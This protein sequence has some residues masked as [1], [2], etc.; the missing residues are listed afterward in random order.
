MALYKGYNSDTNAS[1][2]YRNMSAVLRRFR[3]WLFHPASGAEY[4]VL[5]VGLDLSGKTELLKRMA[6]GEIMVTIPTIGFAVEAAEVPVKTARAE[7]VDIMCWD[8]VG[9]SKLRYFPAF[10]EPFLSGTD[11]LVWVF[12]GTDLERMSESSDELTRTVPHSVSSARRPCQQGPARRKGFP[13]S[14]V[15]ATLI[16]LQNC[17]ADRAVLGSGSF[18]TGRRVSQRKPSPP[19]PPSYYKTCPIDTNQR[20]LLEN[21]LEIWLERAEADAHT[22]SETFLKQFADIKLPSWD[23]YTHIR[24]AYPILSIHG[25]QKGKNI[26]FDG[27]ENYVSKSPQAKTRAF[28]LTMTYFWIQMVHWAIERVRIQTTKDHKK[29]N[30]SPISS[31]ETLVAGAP[32]PSPA[33][34]TL[35]PTATFAMFLAANPFLA[36]GRLW[37][38]YYSTEVLMSAGAMVLP[39][40][41]RLPNIMTNDQVLSFGIS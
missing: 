39:D 40:K 41:K 14:C 4:K 6:T 38:E 31:A 37:A 32:G 36:D 12:N 7:T 13:N 10:F 1:I 11:G 23:H 29:T 28:H 5:M 35:D 27:I 18:T 19:D 2:R 24:L 20:C 21:T 33:T 3:Q 9:C 17:D 22:P 16:P 30:S 25:R 15:F 8:T 34:H 26:I